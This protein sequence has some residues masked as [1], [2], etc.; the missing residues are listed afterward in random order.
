MNLQSWFLDQERIFEFFNPTGSLT[1]LS[2]DLPYNN[3]KVRIYSI[4]EQCPNLRTLSL[5]G[6]KSRQFSLSSK[7]V[8]RRNEAWID[9]LT[10]TLD[11]DSGNDQS[12]NKSKTRE[13]YPLRSL[14]LQGFCISPIVLSAS[15]FKV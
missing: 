10:E 8:S 14:T 9:D 7:G 11:D 12:G 2:V 5:N 3:G 4:L 15:T 13:V 1:Y 6:Q